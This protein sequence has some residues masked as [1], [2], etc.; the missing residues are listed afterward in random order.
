[1]TVV[2]KATAEAAGSDPLEFVM[3]DATVDRYGDIIEPSAWKL[4]SFTRNPIALFGHDSSFVIGTWKNVR[5]ESGKL[6]GR[7]ELLRQGISERLDE[8]RAAVEA[9]VLRAVSVGFQPL[10]AEPISGPGGGQRYTS[11]ELLECSLVSIPAN[12]NALAIAK[13]L[14]LSDDATRLIFGKSADEIGT[15]VRRETSGEPALNRPPSRNTKMTT[16]SQRIENT[17]NELV[18]LRDNL[19]TAID[20]GGD[21]DA[22]TAEIEQKD[23]T[24][25][26]LKRAEKALGQPGDQPQT[27]TVTPTRVET[28]PVEQR[29]V[30]LRRVPAAVAE[31]VAPADYVLRAA[32][33]KVLAHIHKESPE[34]IR[35]R[36]YGDDAATKLIFDHV[37]K[38]ATAPAT[39]TTSGWAA[40]LVQTVNADFM[41]SLIPA[42]VY[43]ELSARGLRLTFGRNG[44]ISIPTRSATPTI[45]GS[46]VAEGAPI[47]VRQGAFSS[48]SLTPKKMAVISTFTREIA[49][50]SVPAIEGLIRNAIQEDTSVAVDSVLL[51]AVAASAIRPAG[52]RNGVTATTATSGGGITALTTD[53]KN[54]VTALI[55]ATNGNVRAPV[56]IMNPAQALSIALTGNAGG[57]F[58][59]ADAMNGGNFLGYPVI[60]SPTVTAGMLI[61]VD[62]ADFV[63]VTGDEPLFDI[64][65]QA[66]LHMEDT[67]PLAIGTAGSPNT[68]AA[69]VRS[70]FQTDSIGIRM[71]LPMNWT[72]RRTGVLAWTQNVTW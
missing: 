23:A 64:S 26:S 51:D 37:T 22:V 60:Q 10:A 39:T 11:A 32:T 1:M 13:Q 21:I 36:T 41:D 72:L 40:Q 8:I 46:F 71:I 45:A 54:L 42:S 43:P 15:I 12:P 14:H 20:N 50:H 56:W 4:G 59:F 62:A 67:A 48:Q 55:G 29:G 35:Q 47:P 44:A 24:L 17:Q 69:P 25:A 33:I 70:L 28:R 3:S 9:G 65:D 57:D 52:L 6:I 53:A 34:V 18:T 68:V 63:S 30:D 5:V 31:K 58:V 38:A 66:T 19:G 61:L 16:L 49:Q 7:L 2:H 27:V